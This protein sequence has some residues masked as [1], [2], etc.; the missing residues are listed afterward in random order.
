MGFMGKL[1]NR[2]GR[3]PA[4]AGGHHHHQYG[5]EKD[6]LTVATSS[7]EA[8]FF[9]ENSDTREESSSFFPSG[10]MSSGPSK[11]KLRSPLKR[12]A[13]R[14]MF[15]RKSRRGFKGE[16]DD[17]DDENLLGERRDSSNDDFEVGWDFDVSG[18]KENEESD[19]L[20]LLSDGKGSWGNSP[21]KF[22]YQL[23]QFE[24]DAIFEPSFEIALMDPMK[25]DEIMF[26]RSTFPN[27]RHFNGKEDDQS[28]NSNYSTESES[29]SNSGGFPTPIK[30]VPQRRYDR[31]GQAFLHIFHDDL[32]TLYEEASM[33][34]TETVFSEFICPSASA[35][36]DTF[37]FKP[38]QPAQIIENSPTDLEDTHSSE[39]VKVRA[40]WEYSLRLMAQ[41]SS[42]DDSNYED[43][44]SSSSQEEESPRRVFVV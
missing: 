32:S 22:A 29:D 27:S 41:V 14:K 33:A 23:D 35:D 20:G 25:F 7:E 43:E 38:N 44:E 15:D 30:V 9:D 10:P 17:R 34:E 1:K 12:N 37:F 2:M 40:R 6:S 31:T 42:D 16:E 36:E 4:L 39:N 3:S 18:G 13:P 21:G 19:M 24:E 26:P 8:Y 28:I 11:G 5:G